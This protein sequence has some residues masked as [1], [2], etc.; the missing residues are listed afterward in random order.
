LFFHS[1]VP[2]RE[3]LSRI[4][5]HDIGLATEEN[6]PPSRDLTITNKILQYLLGGIAVIASETNGQKEV[7]AGA[8]GAVFL[9]KNRDRHSLSDLLNSLLRDKNKLNEARILALNAA[10]DIF[11]WEKQEPKL[12]SWVEKAFKDSM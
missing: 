5:E 10:Q 1:L 7:A 3:L 4:A 9:F 8:P 2:H 6:T 11:C 12:L